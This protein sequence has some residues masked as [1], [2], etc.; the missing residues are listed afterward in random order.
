MSK[1]GIVINKFRLLQKDKEFIRTNLEMSS[2][3]NFEP[4]K[5]KGKVKLAPLSAEIS[6]IICQ[7]TK[8]VNPGKVGA[9]LI[10]DFEYSNDIFSGAGLLRLS[11]KNAAIIAGKSY[12]LP[13]LSL[14]QMQSVCA[15]IMDGVFGVLG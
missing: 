2:Y 1:Q 7:F 10:S 11:R 5:I 14:K 6:S 15:D 3:I 13:D 9:S 8:Q 4:F 12:N